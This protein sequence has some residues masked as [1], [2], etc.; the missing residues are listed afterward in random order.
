MNQISDYVVGVDLGATNIVSLLISGDG[1]VIARD[2][3]KT[4]GEKGKDKTISQI[5]TSARSVLG[6]GEKA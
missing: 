2:A 1:K 4:M 3:R 5:V 6:E